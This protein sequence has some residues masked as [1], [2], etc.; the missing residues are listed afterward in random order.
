MRHH[1]GGHDRE[2]YCQPTNLGALPL[3]YSLS[4]MAGFVLGGL[5]FGI[6]TLRAGVLPRWPAGLLA[7]G[8]LAPFVLAML[9]HPLDRATAVPT[10]IAK[11]NR[12]RSAKGSRIISSALLLA[13]IHRTS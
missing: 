3:L 9:P 2:Q 5:L 10:G 1:H 8:S 6:A 12:V 11:L 4:G 13:L 7:I